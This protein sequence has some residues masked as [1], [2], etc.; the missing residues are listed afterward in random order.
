MKSNRFL[1]DRLHVNVVEKTQLHLKS[2]VP[3]AP[4]PPYT[5]SLFLGGVVLIVVLILGKRVD[6]IDIGL[7]PF[8]SCLVVL[9]GCSYIVPKKL[10]CPH[11]SL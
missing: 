4:S 7:V 11:K 10:F 5:I 3:S 2:F 1:N 6:A 9:M 8:L